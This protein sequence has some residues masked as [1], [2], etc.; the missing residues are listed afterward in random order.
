DAVSGNIMLT[1]TDL[2]LPGNGG[3]ELRFQ[4]VFNSSHGINDKSRW[5]FGFPGMV[6]KIVEKP[7]PP[8]Y[9][10]FQDNTFL[11]TDTAPRFIMADGAEHPTAYTSEPS[12]HTAVQLRAINVIS[13]RFLKYSRPPAVSQSMGTLYMS[14]GTICHYAPDGNLDAQDHP[15]W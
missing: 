12:G 6:M 4:R 11:I 5:R 15:I 7:D 10:D 8:D 14:D 1:F 13:G 3:R 9:F 2:T